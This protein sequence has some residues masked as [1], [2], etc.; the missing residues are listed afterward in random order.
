MHK[1]WVQAV[2]GFVAALA[3]YSNTRI[4][5]QPFLAGIARVWVGVEGDHRP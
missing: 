1:L 3:N 5:G 4:F 2:L